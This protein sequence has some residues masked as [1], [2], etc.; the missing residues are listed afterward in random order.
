MMSLI[1]S[2]DSIEDL[3]IAYGI[4]I[5]NQEITRGSINGY[6]KKLK[7]KSAIETMVNLESKIEKKIQITYLGITYVLNY[8]FKK[9]FF[10]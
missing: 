4:K 2:F 3:K 6:L 7:K 1:K 9:H 5:N 10:K 8:L